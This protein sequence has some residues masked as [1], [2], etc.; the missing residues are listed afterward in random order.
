[1]TKKYSEWSPKAMG[2]CC[3]IFGFIIGVLGIIWHAGFNQPTL[4]GLMYQWF[5]LS[6][7][8]IAV[9]TLVSFTAIGYVSGYLWALVYNWALKK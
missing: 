1:M 6:N 9:G 7:P 3:G 4:A 2:R 5:T 8:S